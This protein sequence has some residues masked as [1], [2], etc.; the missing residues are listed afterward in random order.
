MC[1]SAGCLES[2]P[3]H[4]DLRRLNLSDLLRPSVR[5]SFCLVVRDFAQKLPKIAQVGQAATKPSSNSALSFP[6]ISQISE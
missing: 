3:A 4:V 2:R 1:F 6:K 5:T